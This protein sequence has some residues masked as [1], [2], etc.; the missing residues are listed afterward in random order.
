MNLFTVLTR[1]KSITQLQAESDQSSYGF[2]RTLG[3]WQ[4]IAVGIGAIIGVGIF[5]LAGQQAAVNAGPG[6][7]FSFMIAGLGSGCAALSYAEFSSMIPLTGS[8]YTYSYAV[9]GELLAWIIGWDLLLEYSLIVAVVAIGWSGYMQVL[10]TQLTG[11]ELPIALQGAWNPTDPESG[12]VFNLIAAFITLTVSGLLILKTTW[13]MRVN[14]F[15]V[16]LKLIG[17][18]LVILI[19]FFYID[20]ANWQPFIPP[21]IEDNQSIPHFGW[22]G[23]FSAASIV[24]FACFGYDTLTTAAEE[25]EYPKQDLPKAVLLSLAISIALY[26]AV[27][28]VLTGIVPYSELDNDAPVDAAFKALNLQWVRGVINI[29]AIAGMTSVLFA[30]LLGAA[31]IWFA[32]ARDGLLPSWFAKIHP[33]YKTPYRP[34]LILGIFTALA[35]GFLPIEQVAALV[36]IGTLS[37]F[38]VICSAVLILRIRHPE[39]PRAFKMPMI[40]IIAP[41]GVL[42]SLFL[43]IGWPW[44]VEGHLVLLSGLPIAILWRFILWMGIGLLVYFSYGIHHSFL[45]KK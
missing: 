36:N 41:V 3:L 15:I 24:F 27:S 29:A 9:L 2:Q 13:G 12:K 11:L 37:A 17:V 25:S 26:L 1:R 18:L 44:K 40:W 35:A 6:V 45:N 31:R 21:N 39:L 43:I 4:L 8:T 19:G 23:V 14:S 16:S 32:L 38:I 30:F 34:T 10:I 5:V 22:S 28:L 42:F 20:P 7:V 33:H